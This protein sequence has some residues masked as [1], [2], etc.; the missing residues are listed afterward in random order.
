MGDVTKALINGVTS[1]IGGLPSALASFG[2][3]LFGNDISQKNAR[4]LAAYQSSL[5]QRNWLARFNMTNN[6]NLPKNHVQR[7]LD[8]GVNPYVSGDFG[9]GSPGAANVSAGTPS[10]PAQTIPTPDVA[11][12]ARATAD[13]LLANKNADRF[14]D[15]TDSEI[16]RRLSEANRNDAVAILDGIESSYRHELR[17]Q[18][19]RRGYIE[20]QRAFSDALLAGRN[21]EMRDVDIVRN[22][23]GVW[24]DQLKGKIDEETL[25][26]LRIE[27]AKLPELLDSQISVNRSTSAHQ[28][29]MAETENKLRPLKIT[30]AVLEN[31]L[32]SVDFERNSATLHADVEKAYAELEKLGV[33]TAHVQ[34]VINGLKIKNRYLS[35]REKAELVLTYIQCFETA[36]RG[37]YFGTQSIKTISDAILSWMQGQADKGVVPAASLF[38]YSEP[39]ST[40]P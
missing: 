34:E 29:A 31:G 18:E 16:R 39:I 4:E 3:G 2:L 15:I 5:E 11:S 25:N 30:A 38:G 40:L 13:A 12:S 37:V 6:Y 32:K 19:L 17:Q 21:V 28:S 27:I 24:L 36:S 1:A 33:E 26:R 35:R 9:S 23:I 20:I 7:M 14:D 10:A 8:A 22:K